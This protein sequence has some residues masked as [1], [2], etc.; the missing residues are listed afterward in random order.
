MIANINGTLRKRIDR[1]SSLTDAEISIVGPDAWNSFCDDVDK[2]FRAECIATT[3]IASTPIVVCTLFIAGC[4]LCGIAN[5]QYDLTWEERDKKRTT[6]GV[7]LGAAWFYLF[8]VCALGLICA[9]N[10]YDK[11]HRVCIKHSTDRVIFRLCD[12]GGPE[13]DYFRIHAKNSNPNWDPEVTFAPAVHVADTQPASAAE[14][15]KALEDIR[16]LI[17]AETYE[18]KKAEIMSSVCGEF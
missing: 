3:L 9:T 16:D 2:A 14:R 17:D 8:L 4:A 13:R 7:L 18:V 6:G 1:D 15:L 5:N 10:G 11:V 12:D